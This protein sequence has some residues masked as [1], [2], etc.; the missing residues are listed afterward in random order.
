MSDLILYHSKFKQLEELANKELEE[1]GEISS[2]LEEQISKSLTDL[3]EKVDEACLFLEQLDFEVARIE[4][5]IKKAKVYMAQKERIAEMI[6]KQALIIMQETGQRQLKGTD[7]RKFSLRKSTKT[8]VPPTN[9]NLPLEYLKMQ[10]VI[11]KEKIKEALKQG[12]TIDG[13]SLVESENVN[14]K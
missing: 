10:W 9:E 8:E 12:K 2:A 11:D 14:Y 7:F 4:Q 3:P 6:K 1:N 5:A 13:C